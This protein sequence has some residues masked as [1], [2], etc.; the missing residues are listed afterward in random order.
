MQAVLVSMIDN[1]AD[2]VVTLQLTPPA[3]RLP[4]ASVAPGSFMVT[5]SPLSLF[6]VQAADL[7]LSFI[8]HQ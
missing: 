2:D 1:Q 8:S 6:P 3:V 5:W 7:G 4:A